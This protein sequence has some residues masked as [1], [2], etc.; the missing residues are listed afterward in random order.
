MLHSIQ[1]TGRKIDISDFQTLVFQKKIKFKEM[2]RSQ[3]S[4]LIR[5][6]VFDEFVS[7]DKH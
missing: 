6:F 4:R 3:L 1:K 7:S 5:N 2:V